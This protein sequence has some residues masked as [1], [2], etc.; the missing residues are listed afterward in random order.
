MTTRSFELL[1]QGVSM[2]GHDAPEVFQAIE[3]A[4]PYAREVRQRFFKL[5]AAL[6]AEL[7]AE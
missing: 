6:D 1:M 3:Q 2:V 5:A 4:N 7:A